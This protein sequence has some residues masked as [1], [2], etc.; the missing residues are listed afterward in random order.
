MKVFV[1]GGSG[2]VGGHLVT[3]LQKQGHEV[4][5]GSRKPESQKSSANLHW[6]FADSS[7]LT[8]G[9][10]VL[11]QVDAAYFLSP[12]GQTN[13]YEILSPWI[14]KAKQVRLKKLVLMTAMGVDHAP[15]E[16][17]FRKTEIL[18]EGAGIPWNIIRPNWFMQNFHTFWIAG[19][20]QDQKIYF[21]GGNAK[22]SFIDARDIASV[23]AVLLTTT[24]Y[25]NQAFT[26][27]GPESIDHNEVAKHLTNVSGK[28]IEYVD[29]DPKVFESSLVSAGLSKDYAAFLV[30]IAGALKEG[31]SAPILDTVKTLTGK[32]PISFAEYAKDFAS[33]WK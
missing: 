31:F 8:K 7:N 27:T 15:P 21:P 32:N 10:E 26:L 9:L 4:W 5:A 3:E 28:N 11:E 6:V 1:Y 19:I 30:M 29:V 20:K 12:P 2:L 25:D 22:T 13:Q 16:A 23:A 24:K 33:S 14:E 18:L 17:P